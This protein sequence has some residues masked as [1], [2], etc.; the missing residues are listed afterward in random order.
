MSG[1]VALARARISRRLVTP[2]DAGCQQLITERLK[3]L[4]FVFERIDCNGT[5][6]LYARRGGTKPILCFAE[7]TDVVPI[8][9][10]HKWNAETDGPRE[11]DDKRYGR[12]GADMKTRI[13]VFVTATEAFANQHPDLTESIALH[14]ASDEEARQFTAR[15]S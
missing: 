13:A 6:I 1:T 11:C 9:P 4:G 3:P 10:F 14:I 12:G 5:T 7:Q 15:C 2:D 8:G